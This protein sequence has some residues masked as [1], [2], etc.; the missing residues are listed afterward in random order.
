LA[1]YN[2]DISI[3]HKNQF[4]K[5]RCII[6]LIDRDLLINYKK[7]R[8]HYDGIHWL[9]L[10]SKMKEINSSRLSFNYKSKIKYIYIYTYLCVHIKKYEMF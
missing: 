6:G 3:N 7:I 8:T 1:K 4:I 2:N 5:Y 10:R 9:S